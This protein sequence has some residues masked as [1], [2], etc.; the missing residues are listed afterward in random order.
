[1][2]ESKTNKLYKVSHKLLSNVETLDWSEG[3]VKSYYISPSWVKYLIANK[4]WESLLE[5]FE[6]TSKKERIKIWFKL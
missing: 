4:N 3:V 6:I 5:D 2:T 1:M